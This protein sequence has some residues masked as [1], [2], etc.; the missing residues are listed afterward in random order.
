LARIT[1][2]IT[3]L[4]AALCWSGCARKGPTL[5]GGKPSADWVAAL[6]NADAGQRKKAVHKLGNIGPADA[7]VVPAVVKA[8]QDP[9]PLVRREAIAALAGFG[10]HGKAA[11]PALREIQQ[12]DEDPQVREDAGRAIARL[13]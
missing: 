2:G 7:A 9:D 10:K 8:L 4:V 3:V 5:A 1:W 11:L 12:S 13:Q 6:D